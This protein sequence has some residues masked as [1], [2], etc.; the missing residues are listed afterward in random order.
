MNK[1]ENFPIC[2][3][4][5]AA[6][7]LANGRLE[8]HGNGSPGPC[9]TWQYSIGYTNK[10]PLPHRPMCDNAVQKAPNAAGYLDFAST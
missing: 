3:T 5:N 6:T 4:G 9:P 7:L 1:A 8:R 10:Q 2:T